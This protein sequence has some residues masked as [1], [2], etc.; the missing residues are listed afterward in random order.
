MLHIQ[1]KHCASGSNLVCCWNI[2][3]SIISESSYVSSGGVGDAELLIDDWLLLLLQFAVV[4][5]VDNYCWR[6]LADIVGGWP[7]L[8]ADTLLLPWSAVGAPSGGSVLK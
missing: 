6:A 8:A 3:V 7:P 5:V 1:A 4:V 2:A